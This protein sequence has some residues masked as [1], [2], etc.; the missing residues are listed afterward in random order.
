MKIR[1]FSLTTLTVLT[2]VLTACASDT[3][4]SNLSSAAPTSSAAVSSVNSIDALTKENAREI[5]KMTMPI[6][7]KFYAI[8]IR[9]SLPVVSSVSVTDANGFAYSPVDSVYDT[10]DSLKADTENY[11]TKEYLD[12]S[13]YKNLADETAFYKDINGKLYENTDAVS[14]GK[15]IWDTTACVINELTD[16]GFTVT[17]PYLDLYEAHRSARIEYVLDGGTYKIN[18]WE[19]NLDA[20]Q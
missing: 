2:A 11:F 12:G 18:N 19:M 15:N 5:T 6:A 7:D 20:I 14:D 9:C 16:T 10:L 8:Y 13:F 1:L 17:V 4:S 3:A